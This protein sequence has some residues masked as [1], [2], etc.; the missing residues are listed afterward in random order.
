MAR[1][2][3]AV[4][5]VFAGMRSPHLLSS[6][7]RL[8]NGGPQQQPPGSAAFGRAGSRRPGLCRAHFRL[9]QV[10]CRSFMDGRQG[11]KCRCLHRLPGSGLPPPL[12]GN[13][14]LHR[15]RHSG[16]EMVRGRTRTDSG[17]ARE[18]RGK[19]HSR[20]PPGGTGIPLCGHLPD[21]PRPQQQ[22][23]H[24]GPDAG[25]S[26]TDGRTAPPTPWGRTIPPAE[27]W[28]SRRPAR[29]C[30]STSGE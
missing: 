6:R 20:H 11:E 3:L 30:A 10:F 26:R 8:E 28:T 9:A 13:E 25:N 18:S 14:R 23:L 24:C 16:P 4:H 29:E 22:Y 7:R 15:H 19:S 27:S 17:T 12:H 5:A 21:H 1:A 2:L